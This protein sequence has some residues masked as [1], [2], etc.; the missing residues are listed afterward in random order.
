MSSCAHRAV[1]G[2]SARVVVKVVDRELQC[3]H[4][5][6]IEIQSEFY[7]FEP[8]ADDRDRWH[9]ML[10]KL[11]LD[12][13]L[14]QV[15]AAFAVE[16]IFPFCSQRRIAERGHG[17]GMIPCPTRISFSIEA[18]WMQ[19]SQSAD[20]RL[21]GFAFTDFHEICDRA[22]ILGFRRGELYPPTI[23]YLVARRR[24]RSGFLG[25]R[26]IFSAGAVSTPA[27]RGYSGY[28]STIPLKK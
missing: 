18:V 20:R 7:F 10:F 25:S 14:A 21:E 26:L 19:M 23:Q 16:G 8:A 24:S 1:P 4:E 12:R 2:F 22:R 9:P 13:P 3:W 28:H 11:L 27:D 17:G 15:F 5:V 6:L